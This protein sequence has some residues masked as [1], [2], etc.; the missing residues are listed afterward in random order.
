MAAAKQTYIQKCPNVTSPRNRSILKIVLT[1]RNLEVTNQIAAPNWV[2]TYTLT[3]HTTNILTMVTAMVQYTLESL[4]L[5]YWNDRAVGW[6][7]MAPG[8]YFLKSGPPGEIRG[9][10]VCFP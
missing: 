8:C 9:S 10:G 4:P 3:N 2:H 6:S 1:T 7:E 5:K